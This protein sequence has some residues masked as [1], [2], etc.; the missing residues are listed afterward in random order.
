MNMTDDQKAAK[1][2]YDH[3]YYQRNRDKINKRTL[4]YRRRRRQADPDAVHKQD[5]NWALQQRYGITAATYAALYAAQKG[6]CAICGS[7][8]AN[9][10]KHAHLHVDHDHTTNK[11]RGLLCGRCN[12]GIGLFLDRRDLLEAAVAYLLSHGNLS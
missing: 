5:R 9:N 8:A 12:K 7:V 1:K 3:A 2:A 11:V 4:S 6:C 10:G